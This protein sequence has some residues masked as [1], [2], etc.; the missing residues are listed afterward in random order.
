M[1]WKGHFD[2]LATVCTNDYRININGKKKTLH[3]NLLK[4]YITRETASDETSTGDGPVP[5]ASL[6]VVEDGEESSAMM[7]VSVK[8]YQNSALKN[9]RYFL[10]IDLS[11]GHWQ[12][13]V[14]E[15]DMAKTAFVTMDRHYE[16]LRMRFGMMY[17]AATLTHD[18]KMLERDGLHGDYIDDLLVHTS[19]WKDHVRSLCGYNGRTSPKD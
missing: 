3:T 2:D 7:I 5:A 9:D 16:F 15:E 19:T 1:Q 4:R 14:R 6:A 17:S 13:P 8:S 10:K 18:V 12:I 11:K